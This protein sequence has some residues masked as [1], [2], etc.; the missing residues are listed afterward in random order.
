MHLNHKIKEFKY[1]TQELLTGLAEVEEDERF[2][3]L[4]GVR[5]TEI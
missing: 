2:S 5:T 3:L 4:Q 1:Q